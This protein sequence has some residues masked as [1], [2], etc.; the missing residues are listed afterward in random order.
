MATACP[1][2]V[3]LALCMLTS[4][5]P[6]TGAIHFSL[7]LVVSNMLHGVGFTVRKCR[8]L[9]QGQAIWFQTPFVA[10]VLGFYDHDLTKIVTELDLGEE[11]DGQGKE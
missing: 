8:A 5:T 11:R 1:G 9:V 7:I 2:S 4:L 3:P 10:G 6:H